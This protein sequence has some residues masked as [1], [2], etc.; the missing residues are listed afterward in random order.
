MREKKKWW[1][2]GELKE[3]KIALGKMQNAELVVV[4]LG[5]EMN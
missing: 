3:R 5:C 1:L 4:L 2:V